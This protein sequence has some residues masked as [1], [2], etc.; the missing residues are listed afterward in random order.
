MTLHLLGQL[1]GRCRLAPQVKLARG[2]AAEVGDDR[3]GS[4]P[5]C[6]AAQRLEMGDGPFI[7]FYVTGE[8]LAD[9]G[10]QHLYRD[11]AALGG[12]RTV[13]LRDGGGADGFLLDA[14]KKLFQRPV[15]ARL[16]LAPDEVEGDGRQAVL[17][18]QQ[19]ARRFHAD[20]VGPGRQCLPQLDRRRADVLKGAGIIRHARLDG[21]EAGDAA[22]APHRRGGVRPL[23]DDAQRAVPGKHPAPAQ[24]AEDVGGRS[25][26]TF[27]PEWIATSPPMIGST[28]VWVK[29][30]SR[31]MASNCGIGGKRRI[32]SIR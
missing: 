31:I 30:A 8:L 20:D 13:D 19:V 2:P 5:G 29:P 6:F 25:C 21:A 10:P 3:A 7:G 16:D 11:G 28:R 23:L 15:E 17:K 1:G 22:Q 27:H 9:A 12:H 24:Q 32:D 4:Q 26:Q 18:R 14:G